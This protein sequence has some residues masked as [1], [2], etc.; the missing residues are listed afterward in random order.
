MAMCTCWEVKVVAVWCALVLE[1]DYYH[2]IHRRWRS[3]DQKQTAYPKIERIYDELQPWNESKSRPSPRTHGQKI[4]WNWQKCENVLVCDS[5]I[6]L[7]LALQLLLAQ[8]LMVVAKLSRN[9][10]YCTNFWHSRHFLAASPHEAAEYAHVHSRCHAARHHQI[11]WGR[12]PYLSLEKSVGTTW[13]CERLLNSARRSLLNTK[14]FVRDY[15]VVIEWQKHAR[16]NS[17]TI[18][19]TRDMVDVTQ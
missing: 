9:L 13:C 1:Y 6:D 19:S 7:W 5:D 4:E 18:L 2:P 14:L 16:R 17:L 3:L 10:I 15:A 8:T 12:W 11:T